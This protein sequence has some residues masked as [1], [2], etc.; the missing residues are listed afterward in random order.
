MFMPSFA[1]HRRIADGEGLTLDFKTTCPEAPKLAKTLA[2]FANTQGGSLLIGVADDG[3]IAGVSWDEEAYVAEQA[4]NRYCRPAVPIWVHHHTVDSKQVLEVEV[5]PSNLGPHQAWDPQN[6]RWDVYLRE[7]DQ[8]I[9]AS[10]LAVEVFRRRSAPHGHLMRFDGRQQ[11][12]LAL[13]PTTQPTTLAQLARTAGLSADAL[14][15]TLAELVAAGLVN[16]RVRQGKDE[17]TLA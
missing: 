14:V 16:H 9:L 4:A 7:A 13:L 1:L 8:S 5:D 2:A 12:L 10:P 15:G 11:Q 3:R 17:L 6:Q